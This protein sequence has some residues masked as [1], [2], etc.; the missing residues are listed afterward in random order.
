MELIESLFFLF[1]I[2]FILISTGILI[3]FFGNRDWAE[4]MIQIGFIFLIFWV[5][6][7]VYFGMRFIIK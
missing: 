2:A 3:R 1:G 5:L 4:S 7:I 6:Y